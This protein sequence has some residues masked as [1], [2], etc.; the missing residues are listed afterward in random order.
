MNSALT[1]NA[2][3]AAHAAP[4]LDNPD[5]L[6]YLCRG[7]G[8]VLLV[9]F[10]AALVLG[11]L[12][13]GRARAPGWPRFVVQLLHRNIA[14]LAVGLLVVHIV[15][16]VVGGYLGLRLGYA[17]VPFYPGPVKI[18]TR[19]AALGTDL[20]LAA[21][22]TSAV[23][24]RTGYNAWRAVHA[25]TYLAWV[26]ALVHATGIGTDRATV[27]ALDAGCVV[28]VVTVGVW[29]LSPRRRAVPAR[30]SAVTSTA[31]RTSATGAS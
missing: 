3:S 6:G 7:S 4:P 22:I 1:V 14:V 17:L 9:L 29:R 13:A 15:A 11:Q 25:T 20:V 10:T 21:A 5:A 30:P 23:R 12:T 19:A 26:L 16:P 28:S 24:T 31:S 8:L 2:A 18:W 27:I